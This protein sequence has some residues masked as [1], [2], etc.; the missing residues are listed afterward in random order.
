MAKQQG[1]ARREYNQKRRRLELKRYYQHRSVLVEG[2]VRAV[3]KTDTGRATVLLENVW[4]NHELNIDHYWIQVPD[5]AYRWFP[6]GKRIRFDGAVYAYEGKHYGQ[7]KYALQM[8]K[9]WDKCY[10]KRSER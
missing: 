5:T 2:R 10:P 6:I 1:R 4:V 9:S 7:Y 8:L 3:G